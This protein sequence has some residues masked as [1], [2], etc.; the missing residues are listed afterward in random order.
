MAALIVIVLMMR[1][2]LVHP[3]GLL[4]DVVHWARSQG[5]VVRQQLYAQSRSAMTSGEHMQCS[6]LGQSLGMWCKPP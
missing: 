2:D 4:E 6:K 3:G 1:R 5:S